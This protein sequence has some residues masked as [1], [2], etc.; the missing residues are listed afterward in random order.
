MNVT[1]ETVPQAT[2]LTFVIFQ[3]RPPGEAFQWIHAVDFGMPNLWSSLTSKM[4]F[5]TRQ[6]LL[7]DFLIFGNTKCCRSVNL[8]M[9]DQTEVFLCTQR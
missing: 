1:G 7:T 5:G 2:N 8:E 9:Y 3:V 6:Q 4:H